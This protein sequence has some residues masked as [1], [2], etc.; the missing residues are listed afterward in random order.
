MQVLIVAAA[1]CGLLLVAAGAAGAHLIAPSDADRWD[2]ALLYGFVHTLA[3]LAA[4]LL[5]QRSRLQLVSG[6]LFVAGTV[7]FSGVQI[8]RMMTSGETGSP[9]DV[10]TMLVPVGGIAFMLGWVM[11]GAVA[12]T[13]PREP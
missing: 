13:K 2:S 12:L 7:M 1:A 11:L 6:A 9:L 5:P 8:V 3:A 10:L 4:A